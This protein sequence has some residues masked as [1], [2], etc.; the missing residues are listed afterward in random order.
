MRNSPSG[1]SLRRKLLVASIAA[2][3]VSLSMAS[4]ATA[5]PVTAR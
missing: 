1:P 4:G 5:S 2:T 3:L